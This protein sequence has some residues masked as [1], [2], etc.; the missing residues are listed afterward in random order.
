MNYA[1]NGI[2]TTTLWIAGFPG[3]RDEDFQHSIDF[4]KQNSAFIYQ[5]DVAGFICSPKEITSP[6]GEG[7]LF[8][9][10]RAYPED[11]DDLLIIKYYDLKNGPSSPERF[12]RIGRFE[13]M[14]MRL[15]IPNPYSI[16]E[17]MEAHSR[18][19]KLGHLKAG[20]PLL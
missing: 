12:Q 4:L 19:I 2:R 18:W 14:R 20:T 3:E 9:T 11:F 10:K 5:A 7:A 15:G 16:K 17:L 1:H 8:L 13:K 6:A